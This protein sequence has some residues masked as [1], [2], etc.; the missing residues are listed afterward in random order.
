MVDAT[1][2]GV[3]RVRFRAQE[4]RSPF[5]PRPEAG[6]GRARRW[7]MTAGKELRAY[8]AGRLR[9]FSVPCDLNRLTPFTRNVLAITAKIPY[10]EVKSYRWVA[11]RLGKPRSMRAVGNA[12]ARNTI[13]VIIPCH[14]VVRSNGSLGGYALGLKWKER[15]L[16]LERKNHHRRSR[17]TVKK[18]PLTKGPAVY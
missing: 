1:Q 3:K 9:S 6:E 11:E 2:S 17:A 16:E 14:R 15:L 12:L 13:P 10:G 18:L 5:F 7:K 8:F 4:S